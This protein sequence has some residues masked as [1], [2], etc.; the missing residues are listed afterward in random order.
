MGAAHRAWKHACG[1]TAAEAKGTRRRGAQNFCR[2]ICVDP[3]ETLFYL[4][5]WGILV[6][7]VE[8]GQLFDPRQ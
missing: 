1:N 5:C 4:L 2:N 8:M 7:H 6:E 3:F